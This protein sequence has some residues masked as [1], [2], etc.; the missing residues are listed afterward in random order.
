MA[1]LL[2]QGTSGDT[3]FRKMKWRASEFSVLTLLM[4]K[5]GQRGKP[6]KDWI[7]LGS[8]ETARTS[9]V[10]KG[11]LALGVVAHTCNPSIGRLRQKDGC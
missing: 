4:R 11:T 5:L 7:G 6:N 9:Q 1:A 2:P 10:E 8:G 3:G